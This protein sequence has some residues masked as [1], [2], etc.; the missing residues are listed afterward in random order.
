[1]SCILKAA[2]AAI[3]SLSFNDGTVPGVEGRAMLF[4]GFDSRIVL[5]AAEVPEPKADFTVDVWVCPIAF[6]KSPCPVVCRKA[7]DG[8]HG[9]DLWLD[10]FGKVHFAVEGVEA[11]DETKT[12]AGYYNLQGV[13]IDNPERGQV[14]IVR[15]TDGT[16]K[17]IV[18][19]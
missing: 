4:D 11:D 16:A 5:P 19:R 12:V 13:R 9:W 3:I 14:S 2:I 1:M 7:D 18:V 6:P 15:Y 17:K 10:C 8:A